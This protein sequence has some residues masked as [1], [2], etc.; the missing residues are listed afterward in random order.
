MNG[1]GDSATMASGLEPI[2][3]QPLEAAPAD[4]AFYAENYLFALYDPIAD[5]SLW[6]HL[7]TWPAD[8]GIWEDELLCALPQGSDTLWS[9]SYLRTPQGDKPGGA[10]L[11]YRCVEPFR[12]WQVTYDGVCVRTPASE[13]RT[14][15]VRD[16]ERATV[17]F[18]LDVECFTP[19]WDP[20]AAHAAAMA[21]QAWA[22]QHYQQIVR[23]TGSIEIDGVVTPLAMH[24]ARDHSRGQR[25]H[26]N[27][28][29][30]GHNL[31]TAA[32]PSGRAFGILQMWAPDGTLNLNSG[33]VVEDGVI[34]HVE[35]LEASRLPRSYDL[36]G[37]DVSLVLRTNRGEERLTGSVCT[38]T[39]AT[40]LRGLGMAF[41]GETD[42]GSPVFTQG[43]ARWQWGDEHGWGL[44]ERSERFS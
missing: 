37:E 34:H 23:A 28:H 43:F 22:S 30:G 12:R 35:V 39:V 27:E 31:F 20:A 10:S 21:E 5:L 6:T 29:F 36:R 44:T 14:G 41:G 3:E 9:Y 42:S 40:M 1:S 25:G 11:R 15:R 38:S 32:M 2:A 26:A 4:V 17:S 8:F 7:G 18:E 13:M 24:G 16:G 19:V 33:Y